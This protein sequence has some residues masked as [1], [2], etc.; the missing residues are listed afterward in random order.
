MCQD[1]QQ[2]RGVDDVVVVEVVLMAVRL[3]TRQQGIDPVPAPL[4]LLPYG[5][6]EI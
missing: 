5:A 1:V 2:S 3:Q 6:I 4:M